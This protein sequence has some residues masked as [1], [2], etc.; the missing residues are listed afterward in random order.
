MPVNPNSFLGPALTDSQNELV[1]K[2]GSMKT[3]LALPSIKKNN[4]PK[5]KQISAYDYLMRMFAALGLNP[6]VILNA[7]FGLV[8]DTATGY[9][10]DKVLGALGDSMGQKGIQLSPYINNPLA[11]T[12]TKKQFKQNNRNYLKT[13]IPATFLQTSKQQIVKDFMVMLFGGPASTSL[14]SNTSSN[15]QSYL[16]NNA[17]CGL[18]IFTI[19]NEP[20]AKDADLEYNRAKKRKELEKG[21]VIFEISCQ[22]VKIKLPDNP[23]FIFQGGGPNTVA[24]TLPP[25]PAQSITFINQ[26][27]SNQVQRIN[28]EK[29]AEK[30]GKAF[31]QI[32]VES[33][34]SYVSILVQPYLTNVFT[35]INSA[36]NP[37]Q[38]FQKQSFIFSNCD[39]NDDPDNIEKQEFAR[40]LMNALL[41]DLLKLLLVYAIK[42][43]KRFVRNYFAKKALEKQ[44]R[45]LAKA[46]LKF[47]QIFS[48]LS[49][50]ATKAEKFQAALSVLTDIL[51][52]L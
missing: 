15:T 24:S 16:L 37:P 19:S 25:T 8:F 12:S 27:V 26:Y 33:F 46:T 20:E 7:F 21:E 1:S 14:V 39:I 38:P 6:E 17:V 35:V 18:N 40:S 42:F 41:K 30:G 44:K 52:G 4:I 10:E 2:I 48:K 22:E 49:D 13:I 43:F 31:S 23:G 34:L 5:E 51:G 47:D 29:S 45:K 32:L 28:N 50:A 9:L 11:T 3:I 36:V